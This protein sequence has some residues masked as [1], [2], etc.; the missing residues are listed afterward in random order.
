MLSECTEQRKILKPTFVL[1][2]SSG[3]RRVAKL[4]FDLLNVNFDKIDDFE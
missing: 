2:I 1:L 3:G 4:N